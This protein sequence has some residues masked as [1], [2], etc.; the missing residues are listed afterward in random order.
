MFWVLK[1]SDLYEYPQHMFWLREKKIDFL[2]HTKGLDTVNIL[3]F[4]TQVA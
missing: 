4:Q 2:V 1:R 3:K